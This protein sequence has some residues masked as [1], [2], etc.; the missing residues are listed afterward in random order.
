M[1]VIALT[2]Q[3]FDNFVADSAGTVVLDFWSPACGTCLLM[4]PMLDRL[5][6]EETPRARFAKID[7]MANPEL[8]R[9]FG[10]SSLPTILFIEAGAVSKRLIGMTS[11]SKLVAA[12]AEM[13]GA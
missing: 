6:E 13:C 8:A 10:V 1:T 3:D 9:R 2:E 4:A 12:L 5:S 7:A 11:R